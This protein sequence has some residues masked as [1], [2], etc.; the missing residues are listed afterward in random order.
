[1]TVWSQSIAPM[2]YPVP[3]PNP[4]MMVKVD[5]PTAWS[6]GE[7]GVVLLGEILISMYKVD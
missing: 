5:S 3:P 4:A 2:A 6:S 7:D 1:M